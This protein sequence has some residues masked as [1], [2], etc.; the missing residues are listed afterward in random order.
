MVDLL[1]LGARPDEALARAREIAFVRQHDRPVAQPHRVRRRRRDARTAPDVES[2]VV[3]IAARGQ[4]RRPGEDGHLL[5]A[6]RVAI[7]GEPSLEVADMKVHVADREAFGRVAARLLTR[8]RLDK[9]AHVERP[10][11]HPHA[12]AGRRG[13]PAL[14]RAVRVEL[15]SVVVR[16]REVDRLGYAV[17]GGAVDRGGGCAEA[18]DRP[19]E[20]LARGVQQGEVK[21]PGVA[22]GRP[23]G[24][25]LDED[26]EDLAAGAERSGPILATVGRQT[27]RVA[28][29]RDG[30]IDVRDGQM[31]GTEPKRGA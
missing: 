22:A 8:H 25:L 29:E 11:E 31:D 12:L 16:I 19:R 27:E 21:E 7:E 23:G 6:E 15:D 18:R 14:P 9:P 24:D 2:E 4:E 1:S 3:V 26:E 20:L 30:A 5:E 13:R 10:G 17:V 28:V